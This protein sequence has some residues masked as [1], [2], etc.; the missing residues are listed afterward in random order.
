MNHSVANPSISWSD[1]GSLFNVCLCVFPDSWNVRL[2]FC[3][4]NSSCVFANRRRLIVDMDKS[5]A[6]RN[7]IAFFTS[8]RFKGGSSV[9][10]V[11]I[12]SLL[13]A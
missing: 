12:K 6:I 3:N 4:F 10:F 11:Q 8:Y 2:C 7:I 13:V 9:L 5:L 1:I